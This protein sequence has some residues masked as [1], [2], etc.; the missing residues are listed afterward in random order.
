MTFNVIFVIL[1]FYGLCRMDPYNT[2][3]GT[4]WLEEH[5]K[6]LVSLIIKMNAVYVQP[7]AYLLHVTHFAIHGRDIVRLLDWHM[8]GH[9]YRMIG[10]SGYIFGGVLLGFTTSF[11]LLHYN[12]LVMVPTAEQGVQ[13]KVSS[14]ACLFVVHQLPCMILGILH[15]SKYAT[16][17]ALGLMLENLEAKTNIGMNKIGAQ[18]S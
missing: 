10:R 13:W 16:N 17:R 11:V 4:K 3:A 7:T 1:I 14:I 8:F 2:E 9:V 6:P 5:F 15:Y 18:I 12:H